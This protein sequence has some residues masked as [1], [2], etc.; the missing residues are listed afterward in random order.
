MADTYDPNKFIP[1][2]DAYQQ[3]F[4]AI[5][6]WKPGVAADDR[7]LHSQLDTRDAAERHVVTCRLS[8]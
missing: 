3:A 6:N 7:E 2:S 1:L 5:E 8:N 4:S